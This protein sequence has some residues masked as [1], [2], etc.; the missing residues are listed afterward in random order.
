MNIVGIDP[1]V[2]GGF[3]LLSDGVLIEYMATPKTG[4]E[5]DT[6]KIN[7]WFKDIRVERNIEVDL[8]VIEDVHAI[9]GAS[10]K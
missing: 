8:I 10:A 5:I 6:Q 9:F 3:A 1:G 7:E 4:T 2:N